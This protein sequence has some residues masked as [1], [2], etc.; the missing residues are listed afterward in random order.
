MHGEG[1]RGPRGPYKKH[2]QTR[3][4]EGLDVEGRMPGAKDA[5]WVFPTGSDWA[6]PKIVLKIKGVPPSF[7]HA[8]PIDN[9]HR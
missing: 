6:E 2:A 3:L 8:S 1:K 7:F 4:S 9:M 5:E